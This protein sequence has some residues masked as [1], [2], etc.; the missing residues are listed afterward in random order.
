[1]SSRF[2]TSSERILSNE[3]NVLTKTGNFDPLDSQTKG[4]GRSLYNPVIYLCYLKIRIDLGLD[5]LKES[6]FLQ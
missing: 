1:M 5:P 3:P 2:S 6:F 4:L